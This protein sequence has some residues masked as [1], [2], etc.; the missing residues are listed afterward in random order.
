V[1][2]Y[3]RAQI[4][5]TTTVAQSFLPPFALAEFAP[6]GVGWPKLRL[7]LAFV[8][9]CELLLLVEVLGCGEIVLPV[10][11]VGPDGFVLLGFVSL[12]GVGFAGGFVSPLGV[13]GSGG[14]VGLG[15]GG[16]VGLEGAGF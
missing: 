13:A 12:V 5:S 7:P 9:L 11:F 16:F 6:V 3:T 4:K 1:S 14:F 2:V 15:S 8:G 10:G